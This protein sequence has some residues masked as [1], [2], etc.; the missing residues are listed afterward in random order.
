MAGRRRAFRKVVTADKDINQL[1][2]YTEE[3]F[4]QIFGSDIID[5][6]LLKNIELD[7]SKTNT[8]NH[9]LDRDILGWII[10]RQRGAASIFDSQDTNVFTKKTLALETNAD[11]TVDIWIF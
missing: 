11:V 2:Q 3:A 7:S 8:V 4:E 1:Q 10:I 5:G 6:V 9:K